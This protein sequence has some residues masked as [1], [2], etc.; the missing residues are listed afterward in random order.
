[1]GTID[2]WTARLEVIPTDFLRLAYEYR[3]DNTTRHG[4]HYGEVTFEVPFSIENLFA[5]KN[6]FERLGRRLS[7]SR[8][9]KERL[10][11]P[12][13]RDVDIRIVHGGSGGGSSYEILVEDVVFVSENGDDTTGDGT[14]ENPFNSIGRAVTAIHSGGAY[15]GITTIHVMDDGGTGAGGGTADI[16]NLMIWGS[17]MPHP[18]YG[19]ITNQYLTAPDISSYLEITGDNAEVFGSNFTDP[20]CGIFTTGSGTYIHDNTFTAGSVMDYGVATYGGSAT[21][22]GNTFTNFNYGI[23]AERTPVTISNNTFA[24]GSY[25]VYAY[26]PDNLM[27]LTITDNTIGTAADPITYN[28]IYSH[29]G[30]VYDEISGNDIT[31]HGS[32]SVSGITIF[33]GE[34][35]LSDNTITVTSDTSSAT[36]IGLGT[37]DSIRGSITG[38]TITAN[39]YTLAQGI[40]IAPSTGTIGISGDP[41]TITGVTIN[42]N[43]AGNPTIAGAYAIRL[44]N[45]SSSGYIFATVTG[46]TANVTAVD[47][48][49][50]LWLYCTH[51]SGNAVDW[52]SVPGTENT[53]NAYDLL[54]NPAGWSGNYDVGGSTTNGPV[55]TNFTTGVTP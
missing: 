50:F 9:M 7:G 31:V 38:G 14:F 11:E 35:A 30:I 22:S 52:G 49:L 26:D 47:R 13:R 46:N 5:G 41:F 20:V 33:G 27:T 24:G 6:P 2:G 40:N 18:T 28:G 4:D 15:S 39:G 21:I 8:D 48:R 45:T 3:D 10:V 44:Y 12:V 19:Y 32:G 42:V 51:A 17:G 16:A 37:G 25:G 34:V 36:G 1:M 43:R 29:A 55:N 54:G 23:Y 53:Y